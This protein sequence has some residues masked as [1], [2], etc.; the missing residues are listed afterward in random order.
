MT[1]TMLFSGMFAFASFHEWFTVGFKGQTKGYPWGP[2]NENPWY[3]DNPTIYSRVML[4]EFIVLT[5]GVGL[6]IYFI[7]KSNKQKILYSLLGLCGLL[8]I[9]LVNGYIQ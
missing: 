7:S 2:L 9:I 5:V 8:I 1:G 6:T 4:T 3:Y